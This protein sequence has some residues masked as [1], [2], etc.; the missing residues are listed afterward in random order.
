MFAN[1]RDT[2]EFATRTQMTSRRMDRSFTRHRN[3][4]VRMELVEDGNVI[5]LSCFDLSAVGAYLYSDYLFC[6]GDTVELRLHI[7]SRLDPMTVIGEVVR[8][9]T[10]ESG[11][12]PGMGI[13]FRKITEQDS[14]ELKQFLLRRFLTH[15]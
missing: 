2:V 6:E 15:V 3:P 14:D 7:A 11:L 9:E 10:G 8:V 13:T 4:P 12:M 5:A 1:K